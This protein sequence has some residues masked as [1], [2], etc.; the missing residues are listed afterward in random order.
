MQYRIG[1]GSRAAFS[2]Y[3]SKVSTQEQSQGLS[4]VPR[5]PKAYL[6]GILMG[7]L[8]GSEVDKMVDM[9]VPLTMNYRG[10]NISKHKD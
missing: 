4:R 1:F 2:K 6:S 5:P 7:A 8:C 3:P 9:D 10:V